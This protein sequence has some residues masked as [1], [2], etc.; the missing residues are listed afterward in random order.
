MAL[1]RVVVPLA[2]ANTA[3]WRKRPRRSVAEAQWEERGGEA[4]T[5]RWAVA[6]R[7]PVGRGH[8]LIPGPLLDW[9]VATPSP[10]DAGSNAI[11]PAAGAA[12]GR[13]R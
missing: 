9:T 12:D 2:G 6:T 3:L 1:A 13:G 7:T 8:L 10:S 11:R 5:V 4:H